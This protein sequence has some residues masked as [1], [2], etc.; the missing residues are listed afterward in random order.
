M[1]LLGRQVPV[2]V[3]FFRYFEDAGCSH[4]ARTWLIDDAEATAPS[5]GS[6][7]R[8]EQEP[9]SGTDWYVSAPCPLHDR[10]GLPSLRRRRRPR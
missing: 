3:P 10:R 7:G 9:W 6:K 8:A 5:A 2:G 1:L 4:L